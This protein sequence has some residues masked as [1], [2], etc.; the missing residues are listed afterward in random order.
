MDSEGQ[1]TKGGYIAIAPISALLG[2][3][4]AWRAYY[5]SEVL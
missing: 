3:S 2:V 1:V 4:L 5:P